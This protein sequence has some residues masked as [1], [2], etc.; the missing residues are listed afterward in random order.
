LWAFGCIIYQLLAGRPPFKAGNEYQTFQ[1]I[2]GLDYSF[3]DG[4]PPLAKDLVERLLVLDPLTRLPMEHIKNH[5]FFDGIAWGKGLWKQKA[6]RLKAY[7]PPAQEPIKLNGKHCQG[8]LSINDPTSN[9]TSGPSAPA[10]AT[11]SGRPMPPKPR[12][13]TEL[14]PPSQLD[15]DWS[16]VLTKRDERILKLG[17]MFITQHPP[18]HQVGGKEEPAETPKKFSRFFSSNTVKKRQR[19]VMIT[20]NARVLMCAA[21]TNDKK[22]KEEISLLSAGCAW[23]SYQDSKGLTAWLV[24]TVCL[25]FNVEFLFPTNTPPAR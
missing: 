4:F 14:P 25:Q 12:L 18:G 23:R 1:K 17:N 3:P 8:N 13:I 19:L 9:T 22:L 20:S 7:S 5:A 21:G 24:E 10:S 2:V 15:I 16:P 6:P 11:P